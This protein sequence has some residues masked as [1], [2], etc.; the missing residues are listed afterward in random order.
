MLTRALENGRERGGQPVYNGPTTE[1]RQTG[2][3]SQMPPF[4][5]TQLETGL[6]YTATPSATRAERSQ[7][8]GSSPNEAI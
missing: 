1:R 7:I 6:R 5:V 3:S 8:A 4:C 2:I